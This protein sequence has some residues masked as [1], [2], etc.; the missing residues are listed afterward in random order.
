VITLNDVRTALLFLDFVGY[1]FFPERC[2]G[3]LNLLF[4]AIKSDSVGKY[5]HAE[6]RVSKPD[7]PHS[8]SRDIATALY[9][10]DEEFGRF[11]E[12]VYK[13]IRH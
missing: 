4:P 3:D 7:D 6:S 2:H 11:C 10:P 8:P 5:R 13:V 1:N 9:R 12:L